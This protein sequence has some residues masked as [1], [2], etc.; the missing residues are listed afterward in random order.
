MY[1]PPDFTAAFCWAGAVTGTTTVA[2]Q[3][4]SAAQEPTRINFDGLDNISNPPGLNLDKK[5]SYAIQHDGDGTSEVARLS[6]RP[7]STRWIHFTTRKAA[8]PGRTTSS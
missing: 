1:S 8:L 4:K 3:P 2:S 6:S 5:L 7:R